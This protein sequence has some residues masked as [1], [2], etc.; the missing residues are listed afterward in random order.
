MNKILAKEPANANTA[1]GKNLS[2]KVATVTCNSVLL[3]KRKALPTYSPILKGVNAPAANPWNNEYKIFFLSPQP[4]TELQV[5]FH[6]QY[7]RSILGMSK[8]E[9]TNIKK[10]FASSTAFITSD[11][12]I[13]DPINN[14]SPAAT[15]ILRNKIILFLLTVIVLIKCF[16]SSASSM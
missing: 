8:T 1:R 10:K 6:F 3:E 14:N 15:M 2:I 13:V 12:F 4:N 16:L 9:A 11:I 7:C 5:K